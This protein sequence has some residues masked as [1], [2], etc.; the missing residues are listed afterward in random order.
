MLSLNII[1]AGK[2]ARVMGRLFAVHQVFQ[3]AQILSKSQ[4][5]AEIARN[6]IGT[7]EVADWDTLCPAQITMLAVPD[8]QISEVAEKLLLHNM[9]VPGSILF[10]C[11]GSKTSDEMGLASV[12]NVFLASVHPVC[13]FADINHLARHFTGSICSV[14]GHAAA[15]EVLIPALEKLPLRWLKS[16]RKINCCTMQVRCFLLIIWSV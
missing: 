4:Q 12:E 11:S 10:H 16:M 7:G 1:G 9:L 3:V 2:V 14:E 15:L 6:F 13:S 8:D 5:S